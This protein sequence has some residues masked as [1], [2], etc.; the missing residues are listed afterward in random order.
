MND[1][2]VCHGE[3]SDTFDGFLEVSGVRGKVMG[4][5]KYQAGSG[6]CRSRIVREVAGDRRR[7][8]NIV[9]HKE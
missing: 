7:F 6:C 5:Y 3:F 4:I 2:A 1:R 9:M 8:Y